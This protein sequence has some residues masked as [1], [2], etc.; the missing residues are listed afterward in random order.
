MVVM[1]ECG[2]LV[3]GSC[4]GIIIGRYRFA[5]TETS[6]VDNMLRFHLVKDSLQGS[7]GVQGATRCL[8][9]RSDW[10]RLVQVVNIAIVFFTTWRCFYRVLA[11]RPVP[12]LRSLYLLQFFYVFGLVCDIQFT[13]VNSL[14]HLTCHIVVL[15][16][17]YLCVLSLHVHDPVILH[18]L[19]V[20][21]RS[22][23][24]AAVCVQDLDL[25]IETV[26]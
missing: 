5:L 17:C 16:I 26:L 22:A 11:S 15:V 19:L 20:R 13:D 6:S 12:L 7:D 1:R 4:A 21:M 9:W 23:Q 2:R 10:S 3:V 24:N 14:A 8:P 25:L 18:A